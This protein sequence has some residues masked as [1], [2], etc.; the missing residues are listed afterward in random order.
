MN[1]KTFV[2]FFIKCQFDKISNDV[3]N[4]EIM[5]RSDEVYTLMFLHNIYISYLKCG[6]T[7][8]KFEKVVNWF[9]Q[10][11]SLLSQHR[12]V[13]SLF[14]CLIFLPSVLSGLLIEQQAT[15]GHTSSPY[16]W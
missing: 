1:K 14:R 15:P 3:R 10:V 8:E 13:D 2:T 7:K 11:H 5:F 9:I 6:V 4:R 16:N 12:C